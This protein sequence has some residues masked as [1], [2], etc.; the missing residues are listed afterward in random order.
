MRSPVVEVRQNAGSALQLPGR[1]PS[2]MGGPEVRPPTRL[3]LAGRPKDDLVATVTRR[4]LVR[5]VDESTRWE[6]RWCWIDDA[7]SVLGVPGSKAGADREGHAFVALIWRDG[8]P[9]LF[10]QRVAGGLVGFGDGSGQ[11]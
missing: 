11:W 6:T 10:G 7:W 8:R 1:R 3:D 4:R 9:D 5:S 2:D